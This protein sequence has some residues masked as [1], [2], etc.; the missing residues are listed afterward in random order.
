M[1]RPLTAR[2]AHYMPSRA[3]LRRERQHGYKMLN[4]QADLYGINARS[5]LAVSSSATPSHNDPASTEPAWDPSSRTPGH[6]SSN[7]ANN[8]WPDETISSSSSGSTVTGAAPSLKEASSNS[9]RYD[10]RLHG[11][12]LKVDVEGFKSPQDVVITSNGDIR[13]MGKKRKDIVYD[14]VKVHIKHPVKSECAR[15]I[16]IKGEHTGKWVRHVRNLH[17]SN[18]LA[19]LMSNARVPPSGFRV[20]QVEIV[21]NSLDKIT[22][23]QFDVSREELSFTCEGPESKALH[24]EHLGTIP[25]KFFFISFFTLLMH[26][27][28]IM[29]NV[30]YINVYKSFTPICLVC[31]KNDKREL[32][33]LIQ[34][35]K[36]TR[37]TTIII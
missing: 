20:A 23:E 5:L 21:P 4:V 31:S 10:S 9:W 33:T 37:L 30:L 32:T 22:G 15:W 24:R 18:D 36:A 3:F 6:D 25:C 17:K 19:L 7:W 13:A 26:R 28:Q 1:F 34:I 11:K 35:Y 8:S 16:I 14:P 2:H 27:F 12:L 29:L